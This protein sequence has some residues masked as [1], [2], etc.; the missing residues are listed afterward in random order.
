MSKLNVLTTDYT[1][2]K[3]GE[4]SSGAMLCVNAYMQFEFL[5]SQGIAMVM[6]NHSAV[7]FMLINKEHKA[8]LSGVMVV[9]TSGS[10]STD[11]RTVA[12]AF[13]ELLDDKLTDIFIAVPTYGQS[14]T[15]SVEGA[16]LTILAP[17]TFSYL[18]A[19]NYYEGFFETKSTVDFGAADEGQDA[20]VLAYDLEYTREVISECDIAEDCLPFPVDSLCSSFKV[21]FSSFIFNESVQKIRADLA[22][23]ASLVDSP[24]TL[25]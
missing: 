22:K 2:I 13:T 18:D 19:S 10:C 11:C 15:K 17:Y 1:E 20:S 16:A 4:V 9:K 24:D 21:A 8:V 6:P 12:S 23:A 5:M 3:T 7:V 14:E 25:Q